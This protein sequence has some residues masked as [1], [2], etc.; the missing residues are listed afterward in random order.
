[1]KTDGF[2]YEPIFKQTGLTFILHCLIAVGQMRRVSG[3]YEGCPIYN[4]APVITEDFL[5]RSLGLAWNDFG[6]L[7]L[8]TKTETLCNCNC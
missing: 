4:S 2:P 3:I 7:G 6:I 8:T 5:R 1:M